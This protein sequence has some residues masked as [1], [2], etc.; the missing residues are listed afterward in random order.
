MNLRG[1]YRKLRKR[2]AR[3]KNLGT[4]QKSILQH[5]VRAANGPYK[6]EMIPFYENQT[7]TAKFIAKGL[8]GYYEWIQREAI[9]RTT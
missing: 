1:T 9:W 8:R 4:R 6:G 3:A 5:N 2:V 7:T